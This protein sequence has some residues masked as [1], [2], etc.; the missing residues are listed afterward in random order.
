MDLQTSEKACGESAPAN[1][2]AANG[3]DSQLAH[4]GIEVPGLPEVIDELPEKKV[5][6]PGKL[7]LP[8]LER[9]AFS[10]REFSALF[11][12]HEVW[13]YRLAYA[14]KIKVIHDL[15]GQMMVPRQELDR[16]TDSAQPLTMR[17]PRSKKLAANEPAPVAK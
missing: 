1:V 15:S 12:R 2:P 7:D 5:R 14:H 3:T 4:I 6:R 8:L 13:A 11:G 9:A 10:M 17:R 16:L